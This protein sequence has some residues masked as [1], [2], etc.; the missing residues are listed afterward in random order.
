MTAWSPSAATRSGA[1]SRTSRT[2]IPHPEI[3]SL[4]HRPARCSPRATMPL[5]A[6]QP[7]EGA[8]GR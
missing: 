5:R 1:A 7:A 3:A 2:R 6:A 8:R 4:R